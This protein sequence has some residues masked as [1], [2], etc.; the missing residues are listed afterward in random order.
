M[1]GH[2][3]W[4][5]KPYTDAAKDDEDYEYW[6]K[7]VSEETYN[8]LLEEGDDTRFIPYATPAG[9][10]Q[11][12]RV[13]GAIPTMRQMSYE[14]WINDDGVHW[15]YFEDWLEELAKH[16]PSCRCPDCDPDYHTDILLD[17]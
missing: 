2:Q 3:A 1:N 5:E 13:S 7:H 6:V 16:R 11:A 15:E 12:F 4:L 9:S 10:I 17:R 14:E 8:E